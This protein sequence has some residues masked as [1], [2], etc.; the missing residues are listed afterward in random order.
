MAIKGIF[1]ELCM[2]VMQ[3]LGIL[4]FMDFKIGDEKKLLKA[5]K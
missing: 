4:S 1:N 2:E 5:F 3:H